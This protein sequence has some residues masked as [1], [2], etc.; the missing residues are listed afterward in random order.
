MAGVS[1][2]QG[3]KNVYKGLVILAVVTLVEVLFSL[4]GKGHLIHFSPSAQHTVYLI[5]SLAIIALSLYKAYYILFEFMH[6]RYENKALVRTVLI[7]TGLLIWALI[8]LLMEGKYWKDSRG[9]ILQQDRLESPESVKP[10]G[11]EPGEILPV[12]PTQDVDSHQ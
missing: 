5:S 12:E 6:L 2:E 8:A 11:V 3:K 9:Y 7:P 10:I 1:Y 4:L